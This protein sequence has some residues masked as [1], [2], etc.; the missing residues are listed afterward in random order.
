MLRHVEVLSCVSGGS[1]LGA[2][3]YLELRNLLQTKP[4]DQITRE[5][6]IQLVDRIQRNFLEGVQRNLRLRMLFGFRSNLKVF[7]SR[8]SST[9]DRLADL[10][11]TELYSRVADEFKGKTR[12]LDQ[13][14]VTPAGV[15]NFNPKYDNWR[16][17]N[18]VPILILNATALNTCHNWQFTVSYMGE[19]PA[20]GID[21]QIDGNDRFRRMYHDEAP[22]RYRGRI[23]L[24]EA[25]AASAC[26]PGLFDPLVMDNLY[27]T[28]FHPD[29][30]ENFI[31]R[32][33]DGGVY[34][35]QGAFGLMEQD[36]TV[37]LISD[38]CGQTAVQL[39]P[40]GGRLG[41]SKRANNILM[42]RARES[43]YHHLAAL[44]D[45]GL[46]RGL[47][48]VHLKRGL[49]A[50][51]VD[52]LE[53][54]DRSSRTQPAPLTY[55]GVR[56]DV[57]QLIAG[58]RTDLDSFADTE[59]DALM[60]SGYRMT[61][62]EF[63]ECVKHFPVSSEPEA[64]W[65]FRTIENIVAEP[66]SSQD[67]KKLKRTLLAASQVAFKPWYAST[68]MKVITLV[69]VV[70]L[71]ALVVYACF[72]WWS[73]ETPALRIGQSLAIGAGIAAVLFALRALLLRG[74]HY[75]NTFGQIIASAL[76]CTIGWL[77][78]RVHL[79][80]IEPLYLRSGPKYRDAGPGMY[81][82]RA[83]GR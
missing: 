4:D 30:P 14:R 35:N 49:D 64:P 1:I 74:L 22:E 72:R 78:L 33:V 23:R 61:G 39:E 67:L 80:L 9:T 50:A 31:T 75:R 70:I 25:V 21:S 10:Y 45:A 3:Y 77:W 42:A 71:A 68:A 82:T 36:C 76:M 12:L 6:Y 62:A 60:L 46:V 41:V 29:R 47:L 83:T 81:K 15:S 51:A 54:P 65:R 8:Q 52:W 66:A 34:D 40:G 2:Y 5:D 26:V 59:A 43:Q 37:L 57:Q 48:Y 19:P 56:Q 79:R 38:A 13:L 24:S 11:D 44:R 18:K 20:R 32:L 53:C 16:R 28:T 73:L 58:I 55:Y 7:T 27:G 63:A 69:S 17:R